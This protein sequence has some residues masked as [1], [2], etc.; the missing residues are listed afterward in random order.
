MAAALPGTSKLGWNTCCVDC[1]SVAA[2]QATKLMVS[3]TLKSVSLQLVTVTTAERALWAAAVAVIRART[4]SIRRSL[5]NDSAR[6]TSVIQF[7][8]EAASSSKLRLSLSD[9]NH[10]LVNLS[11]ALL[12]AVD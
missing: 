2:K 7:L 8:I 4:L 6:K 12:L 5:Q 11:G 9:A 1:T 3:A 10:R